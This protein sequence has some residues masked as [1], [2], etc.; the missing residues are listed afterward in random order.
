[1]A[2]SMVHKWDESFTMHKLESNEMGHIDPM[3]RSIDPM[4]K[5]SLCKVKDLS[6]LCKLDKAYIDM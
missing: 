1:M 6:H 5:T 2:K 4:E 3:V